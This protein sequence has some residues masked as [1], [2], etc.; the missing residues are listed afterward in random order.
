MVG[1]DGRVLLPESE[2]AEG[3][4]C[5]FQGGAA[6]QAEGLPWALATVEAAHG[7]VSGSLGVDAD[8]LSLSIS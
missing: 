4:T 8:S 6:L 2:F 7:A 3:L 5:L 1:R